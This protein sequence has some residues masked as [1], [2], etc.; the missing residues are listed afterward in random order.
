MGPVLYAGLGVLES[1][2]TLLED[3]SLTFL[4]PKAGETALMAC[5]DGQPAGVLVTRRV[6]GVDCTLALYI[7][8]RFQRQ[9]IGRA[10]LTRAGFISA[11]FG[12][13]HQIARNSRAFHGR[14]DR[15]RT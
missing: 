9:G 14:G 2:Y 13:T 3:D 10:L 1:M 12:E 4:L 8:P 5:V 6:R 7:H 15:T 11:E